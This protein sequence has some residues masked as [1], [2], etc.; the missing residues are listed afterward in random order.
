MSDASPSS[1]PSSE[2]E[3]AAVVI[4]LEML[5]ATRAVREDSD[6]TPVWRFSGRWFERFRDF[7]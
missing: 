1:G 7:A 2:D 5:G 4:A 6:V 3:M